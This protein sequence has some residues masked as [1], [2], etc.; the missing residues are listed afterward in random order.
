[1]SQYLTFVIVVCIAA[2]ADSTA[3]IAGR[4]ANDNKGKI[5][6]PLSALLIPLI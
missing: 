6:I 2:G 1:M 4:D 3:K 5:S